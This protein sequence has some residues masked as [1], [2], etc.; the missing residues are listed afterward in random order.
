MTLATLLWLLF[1]VKLCNNSPCGV[2]KVI[3]QIVVCN[4]HLLIIPEPLDVDVGSR[5]HLKSINGLRNITVC[6]T[7]DINLPG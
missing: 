7:R 1:E 2:H 6:V 4:F 5:S 3:A